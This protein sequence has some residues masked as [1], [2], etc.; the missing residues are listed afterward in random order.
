MIEIETI[1]GGRLAW[2]RTPVCHTGD[3]G[4]K[5]RP[6]HHFFF[7]WLRG[8]EGRAKVF[9]N[10]IEL[11]I[12]REELMRLIQTYFEKLYDARIVL[13][14][15]SR[16]GA[17]AYYVSLPIDLVRRYNMINKK[18]KASVVDGS[19]IYVESEEGIELKNYGNRRGP[20]YFI[21][22]PVKWEGRVKIF[23]ESEKPLKFRVILPKL[24]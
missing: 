10:D 6:P 17:G 20:S 13:R 22:S 3:P 5:S 16:K 2:T 24:A 9:N 21:L 1:C 18:F 23:V 19:I 8:G 7:D 14:G 4:F 15:R 11:D 12:T